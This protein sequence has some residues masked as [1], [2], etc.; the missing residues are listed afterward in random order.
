MNYNTVP[1]FP[2]PV[3]QVQVEEDTSELLEYDSKDTTVSTNQSNDY[4]HYE[5][6]ELAVSSRILEKY[7]NT[8]QILL[9]TFN[10]VAEEVLGYEKR[11][12]QI[13]TSWITETN[14]GENSQLH[15]HKNSFWS[16]VYYFQEEYP[17]GTGGI[18]FD[19]P[20]TELFDFYYSD[21]DIVEQ[22][23]W[24]S[25]TCIFPPHSKLLL[26]FPSYL[27]HQVFTHGLDTKRCSLAFNI[28]PL[29]NYGIGDSQYDTTWV[30]PSLGAWR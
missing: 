26:V 21:N 24:N 18:L 11:D 14:K 27:K 10:S 12:Y 9:D 20:N 17:E 5:G 15:C 6:R 13:T 2:S 29:G 22:N 23:Q 7:P 28:V 8:K 30:T 19:N 16:C 4:N 3:I 1:L 25:S